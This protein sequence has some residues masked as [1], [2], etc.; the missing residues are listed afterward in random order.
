MAGFLSIGV[1]TDLFG[2]G[3]YLYSVLF[4]F[5]MFNILL[6][7]ANLVAVLVKDKS[8]SVG[9]NHVEL[10]NAFIG[11]LVTVNFVL[12]FD[13]LPLYTASKIRERRSYWEIPMAA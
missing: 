2:R 12:L 13:V 11:W 8:N 5:H 6:V 10:F 7:F 4:W 1:M 9:A 3:V